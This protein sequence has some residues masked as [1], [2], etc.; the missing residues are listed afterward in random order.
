[1]EDPRR[2]HLYLK[3]EH[4]KTVKML[5]KCFIDNPVAYNALSLSFLSS[6]KKKIFLATTAG[7]HIPP[8][9]RLILIP[10]SSFCYLLTV[11][12]FH[13]TILLKQNY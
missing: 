1:M 3:Q 2:I 6:T 9:V 7:L 11:Y 5:K 10:R 8:K 13:L 12:F 4:I